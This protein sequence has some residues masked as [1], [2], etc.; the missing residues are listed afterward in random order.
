MGLLP[1]AQV[2]R[3]AKCASCLLLCHE[4][5]GPA[6]WPYCISWVF[7]AQALV[8]AGIQTFGDLR[9]ADPRRLEVVTGRKYPYGNQLKEALDTLPPVVEVQICD[10]EGEEGAGRLLWS[11]SS[12]G[13]R[14][15]QPRPRGRTW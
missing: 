12:C 15:L 11:S 13:R 14:A 10:Q 7:P 3:R 6:L 1:L 4:F 9:K 8:S 5:F 2:Q